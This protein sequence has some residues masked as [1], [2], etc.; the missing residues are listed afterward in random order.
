M[1]RAVGFASV[2]PVSC[3]CPV[4]QTS[5]IPHVIKA[6][7]A[8][9]VLVARGALSLNAVVQSSTDGYQA[10]LNLPDGG[11]RASPYSPLTNISPC[12]WMALFEFERSGV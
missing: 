3:T 5:R 10:A 6:S 2:V 7:H 1:R 11:S 8:A 4:R 9:T 12:G